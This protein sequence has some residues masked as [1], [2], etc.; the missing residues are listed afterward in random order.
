M[1]RW[2]GKSIVFIGTGHTI[3]GLFL[4][5]KMLAEMIRNGVF[6]TVK[7][8]SNAQSA[9]FWFFYVG[10]VFM[11]LG[12]AINWLEKLQINLLGFFK[13]I[14]LLLMAIGLIVMPGSGF[15]LL[16]LPLTGMFLQAKAAKVR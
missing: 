7:F 15:I 12:A 2:I 10:F 3:I 5:Y 8:E 14:V 13:W 1:K 9:V 11:L 6:N 16:T 4:Y